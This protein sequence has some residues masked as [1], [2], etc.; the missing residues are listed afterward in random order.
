[1]DLEMP[2]MEKIPVLVTGSRSWTDANKIKSVIRLAVEVYKGEEIFIIHGGALGADCL[3]NMACRD[4]GITTHI[5]RP[6]YDYWKAKIGW[7]GYKVAPLRRNEL[8]LDGKI[9]EEGPV[10][11]SLVPVLVLA[12]NLNGS[13]TGGTAHCIGEAKK[14]EIPVLEFTG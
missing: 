14:R 1:M 8:M 3:A 10:E 9:I 13:T 12:F 11:P 5:V 6:E 7:A 4:L 2:K